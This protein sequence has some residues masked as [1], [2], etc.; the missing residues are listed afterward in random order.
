[1]K[2]NLMIPLV[3]SIILGF[4]SAQI[5]YSTYRKNLEESSYNAYI[6]QIG[7]YDNEDSLDETFENEEDY[8]IVEEDG[9]YNVYVGITTDLVNANKIKNLYQNKNIET[10][11]KPTVINNVEFVNN[12]EQYDILISEVDSEENIISI[13][14]VILSSYEE[15]VLGK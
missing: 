2:K 5:V 8:L 11:I 1:M 9:K 3:I 13:S 15:M 6:I 10:Y 4:I 12:L 14:D 7:S